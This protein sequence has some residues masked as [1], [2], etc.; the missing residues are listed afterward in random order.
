PP[1]ICPRNPD[2][3]VVRRWVAL[4]KASQGRLSPISQNGIAEVSVGRIAFAELSGYQ[5]VRARYPGNTSRSNRLRAGASDT[6]VA[7]SGTTR[8]SN[9]GT[10]DGATCSDLS[11]SLSWNQ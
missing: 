4:R 9:S 10:T 1:S 11:R 5:R 6:Q 3:A 2:G 8:V 7:P